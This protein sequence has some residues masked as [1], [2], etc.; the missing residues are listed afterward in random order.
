MRTS[1]AKDGKDTISISTTGGILHTSSTGSTSQK[2]V[3]IDDYPMS[4]A[5]LRL[6]FKLAPDLRS[7]LAQTGPYRMLLT[8]IP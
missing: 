6:G 8:S 7:T 4:P 1:F 2:N 3:E 5:A